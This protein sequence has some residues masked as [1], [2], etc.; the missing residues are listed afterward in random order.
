MI[1]PRAQVKEL[2]SGDIK[3]LAQATHPKGQ[4][5]NPGHPILRL[6]SSPTHAPILLEIAD[7]L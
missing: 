4:A 2:G 6:S 5:L 7:F 1:V 3:S